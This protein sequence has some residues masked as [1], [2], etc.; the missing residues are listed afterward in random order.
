MEKWIAFVIRLVL[1]RISPEIREMIITW[2]TQ[3][4]ERA[5]ATENPFD[6]LIVDILKFLFMVK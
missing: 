4:E 2:L 1:E 3:A 5:K 6:D